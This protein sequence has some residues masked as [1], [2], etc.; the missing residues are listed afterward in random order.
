MSEANQEKRVLRIKEVEKIVGLKR[1]TIYIL[2]N[3]GNFPQNF[4][5][6]DRSVG[7]NSLEIDRWIENRSHCR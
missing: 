1:P 3:K 7:W 4:K 5:L 6:G 2:M